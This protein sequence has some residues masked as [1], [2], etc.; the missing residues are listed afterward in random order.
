MKLATYLKIQKKE[1]K[2]TMLSFA[3]RLG[4]NVSTLSRICAEKQFP[5]LRLC[6]RIQVETEGEVT[7][8]DMILPQI[9]RIVINTHSAT[10]T[11]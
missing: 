2:L 3:K 11:R 5:S 4:I 1:K 7:Y 8:Q 10:L 9:L 6:Y